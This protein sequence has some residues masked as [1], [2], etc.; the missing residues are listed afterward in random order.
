MSLD[1]TQPTDTFDTGELELPPDPESPAADAEQDR[2]SWN[3]DD[4]DFN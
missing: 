4:G 2:P 3:P 1:Y